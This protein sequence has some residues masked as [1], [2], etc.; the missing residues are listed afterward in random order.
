MWEDF[1]EVHR[2]SMLESQQF[3]M[4]QGQEVL[5]EISGSLIHPRVYYFTGQF[6]SFG[7]PLTL[8][9]LQA[10]PIS[11]LSALKR[12]RRHHEVLR[13]GDAPRRKI[14]GRAVLGCSSSSASS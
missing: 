1:F 6:V 14:K 2:F 12:G 7:V 13:D 3:S 10:N 9:M 4:R 11:P 8:K 5:T